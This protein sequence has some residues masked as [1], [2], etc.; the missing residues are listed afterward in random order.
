MDDTGT[1][2]K[3][4][5]PPGIVIE[6]DPHRCDSAESKMFHH[7]HGCTFGTIVSSIHK[8]RKRNAQEDGGGGGVPVK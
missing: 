8:D 6:M 5:H 3:A 2:A 1:M 7:N 4:T